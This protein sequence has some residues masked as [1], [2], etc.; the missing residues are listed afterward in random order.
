MEV[1]LKN[2]NKDNKNH[3][4]AERDYFIGGYT[5]GAG[6]NQVSKLTDF[7]N[8]G[9]WENGWGNDTHNKPF[10]NI[11]I[12]DLFALKSSFSKQKKSILK[13]SAIGKV[14]DIFS[15]CKIA[16]E[17]FPD[18][19]SFE[20]ELGKYRHTLIQ[21][22]DKTEIES[23]FGKA[24]EIINQN[25]KMENKFKELLIANKNLILTGAPGTGK[26]YLAK[27]IAKEMGA[28]EENGHL[29]FV[30]FHPS[31]DYTDFVEGLRP[32][33]KEGT[34]N[35]IGFERKNGVF[36]EFCKKALEVT[37]TSSTDDFEESWDKLIE[38]IIEKEKIVI[39]TKAQQNELTLKV[40]KNGN[41]SRISDIAKAD[42]S[43]TKSN[44]RLTYEG[45][46]VK[47]LGN[48]NLAVIEYLKNN[49]GLQKYK[50]G[51]TIKN[52]QG[53]KPFVFIIDEI[54]RGEI[55]KI[56]GE[57]FFSIDPSYRGT[58]GKVQTQ[59]ANMQDTPNEFDKVLGVTKKEQCGH[60][61]IPENV[62]II[63]TMNDID[64]SVES[65]D[66]AM[67]RRF[68]WKEITAEESQRMFDGETWKDEAI[69][70]MNA[71]NS[72]ISNIQGLGSAYHIGAA[73]F[74]NNLPKYSDN[75]FENLWNYHLKTLLFEYLRGIPEAEKELEKLENAYNLKSAS[76]ENN[77]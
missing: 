68:T 45:K 35:K 67:R 51:I 28:T 72:I 73:Y 52:S 5:W 8:H 21:I 29:K 7:I 24:L 32:L 61:F 76:D 50:P 47:Y 25:N 60:F 34:K 9:I 11:K 36:K 30:Q 46:P 62:H 31:Y 2:R 6:N 48:Y 13:I 70:R 33:K 64:R 77:G 43:L 74:K 12:G 54:N 4:M 22:R 23:I 26:T 16:I 27:Q 65:F 15:D 75:Q 42:Y 69:K 49:H 71:L 56:F 57:L 59:Y 37:E 19:E 41:L 53:Q 66:F 63:G 1:E 58:E 40:N 20:L 44:V 18:I 10:K 55:S 17:W 39:P 3:I 38:E 14:T